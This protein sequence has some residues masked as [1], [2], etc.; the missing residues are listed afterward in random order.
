M[1][2]IFNRTYVD[3]YGMPCEKKCAEKGNANSAIVDEGLY[4]QRFDVIE[5]CAGRAGDFIGVRT[6][7]GY[8]G[9]VKCCDVIIYN[10]I[11]GRKAF[12]ECEKNCLVQVTKAT[13]DI[14]AEPS[15]SSV[16]LMTVTRGA[17]LISCC[18]VDCRGYNSRTYECVE[19]GYIC[20]RLYDGR[21]G[22]IKCPYI[23]KYPVPLDAK[24]ISELSDYQKT[25]LRERLVSTAKSYLG[26]QY[27]WGG[28]TP[29][30]IDCSGLTSMSYM[31][32]GIYIYRDAKLMPGFPIRQIAYENMEKG[33]LLYFPGHIAM[34]IGD[35]DYIHSTA[36]PGSDGVV[37][38]SFNPNKE[39]YR[40][41]LAQS[42]Y[43]VGSLWR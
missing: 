15:V 43:A 10:D 6:D 17:V 9:Y 22:Y 31:L 27:R 35:D 19:S 5:G 20:V 3:I 38:N 14:M 8:E 42:I 39:N 12:A 25:Q 29:L 24:G 7:Y 32:N 33:D 36:R 34:Y 13:A 21:T 11:D 30:G 2:G 37:I 26:T 16:R 41:D 23:E 1:R 28:K 40:Q 4:G 18:E